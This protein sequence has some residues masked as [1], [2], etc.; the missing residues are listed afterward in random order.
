M[1]L[2][3]RELGEYLG[4]KTFLISL[5][6][7]GQ[8]EDHRCDTLPRPTTFV[9]G[10]TKLSAND[11]KG[12]NHSSEVMKLEGTGTCAHCALVDCMREGN[13]REFRRGEALDFFLGQQSEQ[14]FSLSPGSRGASELPI[15]F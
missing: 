1:I 15:S 6:G 7:H 5:A 13:R 9:G 11:I 14:H 12:P 8:V 2:F 10:E 4:R 3:E